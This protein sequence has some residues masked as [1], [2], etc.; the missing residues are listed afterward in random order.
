M[1]SMMLP[2]V[3]V[4]TPKSDSQQRVTVKPSSSVVESGNISTEN[5]GAPNSSESINSV[6]G[7]SEPVKSAPKEIENAVKQINDYVQEIHRDIEFSVDEDTGRSIIR[8]YDSG[9]EELIRQIPSEEVV[10][11]AKNLKETTGLLFKAKA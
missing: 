10:E 8:V 6:A 9:T 7:V 3:T 11:L 5:L 2:K 1:N 4:E